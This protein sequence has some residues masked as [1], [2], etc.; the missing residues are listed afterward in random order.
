MSVNY[1]CIITPTE[2][3]SW[4]NVMRL[5]LEHENTFMPRHDE[6]RVYLPDI[7]GICRAK[8]VHELNNLEKSNLD[9]KNSDYKSVQYHGMD[10]EPKHEE[11]RAILYKQWVIW[12]ENT[13]TFSNNVRFGPGNYFIIKFP[14][15]YIEGLE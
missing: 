5:R 12:N 3:S 4:I 7:I 8:F 1:L 6:I 9:K 15:S 13:K 14:Q 10:S 11:S 2:N